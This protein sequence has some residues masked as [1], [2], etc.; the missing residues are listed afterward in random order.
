MDRYL[1]SLESPKPNQEDIKNAEQSNNNQWNWNSN[2]RLRPDG[3]TAEFFKTLREVTIPV[4]KLFNKTGV[5][6][7]FPNSFLETSITLFP[8]PD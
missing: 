3:F 4:L 8:K 1:D 7:V 5:E 6:E 2:E